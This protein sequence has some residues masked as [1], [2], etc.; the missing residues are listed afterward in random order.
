MS[1]LNYIEPVIWEQQWSKEQVK[2]LKRL[3]AEIRYAFEERDHDTCFHLVYRGTGRNSYISMGIR[4]QGKQT[5]GYPFSFLC[6]FGFF[7]EAALRW[8]ETPGWVDDMADRAVH[9]YK[10][11]LEGEWPISKIHDQDVMDRT[12]RLMGEDDPLS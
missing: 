8:I 5:N 1:S 11:F 12:A 6:A 3:I 10:R 9:E 4:K 2:F 7:Y